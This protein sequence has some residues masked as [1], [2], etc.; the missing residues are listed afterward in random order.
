LPAKGRKKLIKRK[1]K[2]GAGNVE[3]KV[4]KRKQTYVKIT[5]KLRVYLKDLKNQ[6]KISKELY[7]ATRKKIK[8][9]TFK[10]KASLKEYIEAIGKQAAN[11]DAEAKN[12]KKS[13]KKQRPLQIKDKKSGEG[14]K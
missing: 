7:W 6:D 11:L 9:R 12:K 3:K 13:E 10:S 5:R 14:K 8:M 2:K 1:N 4:S